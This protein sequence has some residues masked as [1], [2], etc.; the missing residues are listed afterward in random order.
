MIIKQWLAL[1]RQRPLIIMTSIIMIS[2]FI[3]EALVTILRFLLPP[4]SPMGE[5]VL[6]ALF[7]SIATILTLYLFLFRSWVRDHQARA[8]GKLHIREEQFPSMAEPAADTIFC[9]NVQ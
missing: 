5:S 8:K 1:P 6:N 7:L 9:S 3:I 4:L 2:V